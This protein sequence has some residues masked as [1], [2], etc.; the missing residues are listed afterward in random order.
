MN[1]VVFYIILISLISAV[2]CHKFKFIKDVRISPNY[3]K[4][5]TS[6]VSLSALMAPFNFINPAFSFDNAIPN[7]YKMP[8]QNG[9]KPG[10]LGIGKNGLLRM[11]MKPSPNCFS[12]TADN[13]GVDVEDLGDETSAWG[14]DIHLIPKWSYSKASVDEAFDMIGSALDNYTPGQSGIDGGGFK[15]ITKDS[16]NHYYYVQYESL[17]RG[18]IDDLE[19]AVEDVVQG[20]KQGH[21]QVV[22]SSRLGYLDYRVNAKRLNFIA[23]NLR[24]LGFT[25]SEISYETHP[26]YFDSNPD[27]T[28]LNR[29]DGLGLGKKKY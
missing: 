11:C 2:Y 16:K 26:V 1:C 27:V 4:L 19:I 21:V 9:P 17:K 20:Q 12:T 5:V 28:T 6:L 15:V 8:K 14:S 29:D 18:Y 25:A 22:S 13:L 3:V 7:T 24:Q 10:N 23:A